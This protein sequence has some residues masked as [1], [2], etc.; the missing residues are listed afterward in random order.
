VLSDESHDVYDERR[1]HESLLSTDGIRANAL[2]APS[3]TMPAASLAE[4][5]PDSKCGERWRYESQATGDGSPV[6]L[7]LSEAAT[8][9]ARSS[10]LPL[11]GDISRM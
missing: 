5:G 1:W 3:A 6:V 4:A 2:N 9:R 10:P 11:Q 8:D 7:V